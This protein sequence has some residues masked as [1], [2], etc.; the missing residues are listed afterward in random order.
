MPRVTELRLVVLF[1]GD[2][3]VV[4]NYAKQAAVAT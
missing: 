4:G 3:I 2:D 1:D